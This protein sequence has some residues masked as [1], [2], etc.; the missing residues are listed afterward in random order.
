MN[1]FNLFAKITLDDSEYKQKIDDAGKQASTF[2][3]KFSTGLKVAGK[4]FSAFITGAALVAG[5]VVS[6]SQKFAAFT[7]EIDDN[8]QRLG[9]NTEEYQKWAMAVKL[10][11]AETTTF[12]T[13]MREVANFSTLL[14][15]GNADALI[16]LEQ[17]GIGYQ[18]FENLSPADQFKILVER[19]QGVED[20]T[21]KARLAQELFG[22]RAYQELMP[23]LNMEAGALDE[24]FQKTE[25]LGLV[26]S[27]DAVQAG[28]KFGDTLDIIKQ[29][30][31]VTGA[32]AV[33]GLLP[34]LEKLF[35]GILDVAS[36]STDAF[37]QITEGLVGI[38]DK[39]L[40]SVTNLTGKLPEIT[41]KILDM[42]YTITESLFD[43]D[44]G[45]FIIN[46]INLV[47]QVALVQI[48]DLIFKLYTKFIDEVFNTFL[49]S[50]GLSKLGKLGLG[51]AEAVI[52]GLI[53][54]VETGLNG[55]INAANRILG[56]LSRAWTWAGIPEIPDI[57][58]V[59]IP[60]V[61]FYAKGGMFDKG[62]LY[63]MAGESG[64]EI[65]HQG[66][67][68]TG[69]ANVEQIAD[70][71]YMAMND[72]D[73]KGIIED[74]VVA[75]VNGIVS[76]LRNGTGVNTQAIDK[77]VVQI[78]PKE[79]KEFVFKIVDDRLKSLGLKSLKQIGG[80]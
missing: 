32:T 2:G 35:N 39:I 31:L 21:E 36:G 44:W 79:I 27:E 49:T 74:A 52:N 20:Q 51:I 59:T 14:A 68:G 56:E 57:P 50:E 15:E 29:K 70:A 25:D 24:L 11:G 9:M 13:A 43:M 42:F 23:L 17:L 34:D 72:Y 45:T 4:A 30:L 65:V 60:K 40:N 16:T 1:L 7:G 69:V 61:D 63:A 28:A 38:F 5:A 47:L 77:I 22:N 76:G 62:T 78:G 41:Q 3:Q 12:K 58:N 8:A 73:L 46:L 37:D 66:R 71:Q 26:M 80:Q 64:A 48:P 55:V 19:L 75:I 6:I 33:S 67:R 10:A 53:S 18:E 54:G